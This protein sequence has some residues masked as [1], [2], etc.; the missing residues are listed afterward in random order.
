[1]PAV[2]STRPRL[3]VLVN[4]IAGIGGRVAFRG[5]DGAA[6][7][8]LALER[9]A[10][11]LAPERARRALRSL[12]ASASTAT[13]AVSVL[14]APGPMG[15]QLAHDAGFDVA[16]TGPALDRPTTAADTREAAREMRRRGVDLLLFA[17]GDGTARDIYDAIG[18][19]LPLLGIPAG[20]KMHSG[21]FA[22]TPDAAARAA[23]AYLR[24]PGKAQLRE[25]DIADADEDA[26]RADRVS[27]MLHGSA[28]VPNQ[29]ALMLAAKAA[30][31]SSPGAA[32]DA[33]CR[34]IARELAPGCLYLI[35]PGTTT[36]GVLAALGLRGTLLGVDAVI[37]GRLV[38]VDLD[39]A[40][41][42]SALEASSSVELITGLV[43]GQGSLFGRG[44]R[45][46][47]PAVL[48]RIGRE[49]I[50]IVS[51]ADKL[52]ALDPPTLRLDTGDDELDRELGGYVR[53]HVAPGRTVVM[54]V[55]T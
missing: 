2:G 19:E 15:A 34:E 31:P 32:L 21:V 30:S 13:T 51:A 23:E 12:A 43:G 52:F 55:S 38:G 28:R 29:P 33:L 10:T 17:G 47:S 6:T 16:T 40:A 53:V 37:D 39:E 9:G 5:S 22:A 11:P 49:R 42:L 24:A 27:T 48:R 45:Q 25:A 14:A 36:A 7:L 4:P 46:L 8:A 41:L 1:M 20:V 44:N 3:G 50:R 54:N 18:D 35:G 26:L